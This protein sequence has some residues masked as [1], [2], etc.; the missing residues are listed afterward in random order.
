MKPRHMLVFC[1]RKTESSLFV[2]FHFGSENKSCEVIKNRKTER[3]NVS[4]ESSFF[5]YI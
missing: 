2:Q 1:Q 3:K 4:A 5:Y